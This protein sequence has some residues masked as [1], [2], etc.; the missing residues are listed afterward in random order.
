MKTARLQITVLLLILLVAAATMFSCSRIGEEVEKQA[1]RP[2]RS[3]YDV[4]IVTWIGYGPLFIAQEKGIFAENG[5]DVNLRILDGPGER[6][7]AYLSGNI[8]FFPNTP[9]AFAIFA[10]KGHAGTMVMP[11]DESHGADGLVA[12]RELKSIRDLQGK[13]VGF[14]SGISSHFFL[15]YILEREKLK[16]DDVM[17]ENLGAGEAG[18]AF[19][20]GRLDAAVTWEPWLSEAREL[21]TAHVLAT[22]RDTPGLLVDVLMVKPEVL[23][24]SRDDVL[25]FMRSWFDAVDY[26]SANPTESHDIIARGLS[27]PEEQV[28]QMLQDVKFY[29]PR[30]SLQYF[31][32]T[33]DNS[34]SL[35]GPTVEDIFDKAARLYEQAGV[36]ESVPEMTGLI[37]ASLLRE[38]AVKE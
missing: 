18:A 24:S 6:E 19:V 28:G 8:D 34:S 15:L 23:E 9:D 10:S 26:L 32:L 12:I 14:Q 3:T 4:G 38:M 37:D 30:E 20:A 17:Q 35:S 29:N 5:I 13:R 31:G 2:S 36:I 7:S 25:A 16:S 1:E 21:Q 22:T 27:I 11:M 33:T